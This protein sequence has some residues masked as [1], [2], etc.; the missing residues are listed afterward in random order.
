MIDE[1]LPLE[2]RD[3]L[4]VVCQGDTLLAVLPLKAAHPAKPGEVSL[5]LTVKNWRKYHEPRS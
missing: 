3:T 5:C 2:H 4:P 1:K